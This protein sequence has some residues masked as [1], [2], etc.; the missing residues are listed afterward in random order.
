VAA[1]LFGALSLWFT[2]AALATPFDHDESQ[3]VAGAY[4]SGHLLI[5]RDFLYLQPPLHSWLFAPFALIFPDHILLSMRLATAGCAVATLALLMAALRIGGIARGSAIAA[6]LLVAGSAAFQFTGSVVRNDMLPTL[7]A[8]AGLLFALLGLERLRSGWWLAAGIAFGLAISTKLNFAPLGL[9][10]GLF[11]LLTAGGRLWRAAAWLA[12]GALIGLAPMAISWALAPDR[13]VYGVLTYGATAPHAWYAA[14]G[15]FEEL[16]L[17]EKPADLLK[18]FWKGPALPGL[19]LVAAHDWLLRRHPI[20][21]GRRLAMWMIVGALVGTALPTPTQIQYM[22]PLLPPL[23]LALGYLIDD[24]RRLPVRQ[25]QPL[26]ILLAL[27]LIPGMLPT[28]KDMAAMARHGSPVLAATQRAD[29]IGRTVR[30]MTSD[31]ELVTLSP[32]L[33]LDSG[34]RLDPRF[35]TGPFVYRTG[36][37]LTPTQA[38]RYNAMIPVTLGDLDED[39]PAAIL[40]GYELG[41]RNLPMRP[42]DALITYARR[43]AYR[44]VLMPDGIGQLFVRPAPPHSAPARPVAE[45]A[46]R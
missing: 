16:S 24:A 3:Y 11:V 5:F 45:R 32:H 4:F 19:L 10:I 18:Y 33:A 12:G 34:L 20:A 39:P 46:P 30:A 37:L 15:A 41:T 35:A 14:N 27:S 8:S 2:L 7:L 1:L 36:W 17:L 38:R 31:D 9:A 42:D 26:F 44:L 23:A 29:W 6:T 43:R 40:T 13:F 28:I 21:Q 25:R 22:M